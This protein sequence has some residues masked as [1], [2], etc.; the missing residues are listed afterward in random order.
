MMTDV[1][2]ATD[3]ARLTLR[4]GLGAGA[5]RFDVHDGRDWQPIFRPTP[6][7]ASHPF[8][9]SNIV[10]VPFSGRVS[11]GGFPFD[12]VFHPLEPTVATEPYPIHGSAF[13]LPWQVAAQ[14]PDRVSLR[15]SAEGPGPFRYDADLI[16]SLDGAALTMR[17]V[18]V[19]R[20][21][22]LPFGLG[23][24]PWFVRGPGT[25]LFAPAERLWLEREDHLPGACAPIAHHPALDFSEAQVLP[26]SWVNNGFAGWTRRARIEW[27]DRGMAADI[28]ASP[29]L[30]HYV[31]FS[32]SAAA[33]YV[34]FEPVSHAT[35]ALNLAA[36]PEAEGMRILAPGDALHADMRIEPGLLMAT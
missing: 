20:G 16:C 18:V 28:T 33:D 9:L 36:G 12:G 15:L 19:N 13:A 35:D 17:L 5:T 7:D 24:H 23:F 14:A 32:P 2:I 3:Q 11:G 21:I 10:L 8:A 1:T 27:P 31:L 4:P 25:R 26:E 22:R 6:D 30:H 29:M 34:C